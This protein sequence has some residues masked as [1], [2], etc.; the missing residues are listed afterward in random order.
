MSKKMTQNEI[1]PLLGSQVKIVHSS[2]SSQTGLEG[3]V[4]SETKNTITISNLNLRKLMVEKASVAM[5]IDHEDGVKMIQLGSNLVGRPF[6]RIKKK[7]R[8]HK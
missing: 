5:E 1:L 3:I 6:D 7:S 4:V 2:N 8:R